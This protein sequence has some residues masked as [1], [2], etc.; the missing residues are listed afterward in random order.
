M[1][2]IAVE[3]EAEF[4]FAAPVELFTGPYLFDAT[5]RVTFLRRRAR[6]PFPDDPT[7]S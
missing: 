4:S 7:R 2:A 1:M 6:Q 5:S 3:T